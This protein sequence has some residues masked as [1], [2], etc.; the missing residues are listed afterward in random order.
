[1]I[2]AGYIDRD[3]GDSDAIWSNPKL[4][5]LQHSIEEVAE[6]LELKP[7]WLNDGIKAYANLLPNDFRTR[8]VAV[9]MFGNLTVQML[10]RRDLI[11]MKLAAMRPRDLDDVH[12][13]NP[14]AGEISFVESQLERISDT[15]PKAALRIQLY[16]RQTGSQNSTKRS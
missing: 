15:D 10:G 16:L 2:L 7:D 14:T 3:T 5:L 6:E 12:V 1:M 4:S 13:M 8:C 11:L 9:G